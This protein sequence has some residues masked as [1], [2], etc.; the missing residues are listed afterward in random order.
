MLQSS[1]DCRAVKNIECCWQFL[2]QS[3]LELLVTA[4]IQAGSKLHLMHMATSLREGCFIEYHQ[5]HHTDA[6]LIY[7]C[8]VVPDLLYR[9]TAGAVPYNKSC[10]QMATV[11]WTV[12]T[13][14]HSD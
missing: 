4:G 11:S 14:Y 10:M 5:V 9:S 6:G 2:L 7:D 8:A 13:Q 3:F 1:S 12:D